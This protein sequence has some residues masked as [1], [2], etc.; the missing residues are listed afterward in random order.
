MAKNNPKSEPFRIQVELSEDQIDMIAARAVGL[1]KKEDVAR[2]PEKIYSVN[3]LAKKI[4]S[5]NADTIRRHC[6]EGILKAGNMD[7]QKMLVPKEYDSGN[8]LVVQISGPSMDDG[9]SRSICDGDKLLV[10]EIPINNGDK[11]PYRNNLFVI[12]SKEG[13]VCKQIVSQDSEK[14]IITCRSFNEAYDDY[15]I[16]MKDLYRVFV[17]RKIVERRVQI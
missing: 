11:L 12:V 2:T 16:R 15:P 3:E 17:V 9:T 5:V 6:R 13:L 8:F 4:P 14:G 10:K 7:L 1:I